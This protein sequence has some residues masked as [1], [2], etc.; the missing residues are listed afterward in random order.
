MFKKLIAIL[1]IAALFITSCFSAA[2]S[3]AINTADVITM[4][5]VLVGADTETDTTYMDRNG[6]GS[7]SLA[8][9]IEALRVVA[10]DY[11]IWQQDESGT[12]IRL[13]TQNIRY[14]NSLTGTGDGTNNTLALRQYRFKALVEKYDPDVICMQEVTPLW[15]EQLQTLLG[16]TYSIEYKMRSE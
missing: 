1:L 15:I 4:L 6:D 13:M 5:R 3:P 9:A 2:G 11:R 12:T 10:G 7:F 8:D 16:D 14:A